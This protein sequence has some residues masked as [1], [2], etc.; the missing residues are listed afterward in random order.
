MK[1][2]EMAAAL[3]AT[4]DKRQAVDQ[5][6]SDRPRTVHPSAIIGRD[7]RIGRNVDIGP[8]AV[9]GDG[10]EIG[11]DCRLS[12]HAVIGPQ[13]VIGER[14][15]VDSFAVVGGEPQDLTYDP[16]TRSGVRVGNAVTIR[17]GVTIHRSTQNDVFTEIS[18]NCYLMANS[19]V[20][21]DCRLGERV[22][23]SNNVMLAGH[24]TVEARAIIGG[25]AGVHQHVRIGEGA[26]VGGNASIS[27]DVPPFTIAAE[28]NRLFGLNRIGL[29]RSGMSRA[30]IRDLERCYTI[31]FRQAGDIRGKA[32][33]ALV[34]ASPE[35]T[36]VGLRFLAFF[37][38]GRRGF[39]FPRRRM[40]RPAD[41]D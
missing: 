15:L 27:S 14:T 10:S 39:S 8:F 25:G 6:R 17:E 2:T 35:R 26:M 11:D 7:V 40:H 12:T 37:N 41:G 19:H 32:A 16:A 28:R 4:A 33:S 13:T 18:D 22:V 29:R 34:V 9:I 1:P 21:H 36:A 38:A 30:E 5:P 24:V 3:Y 23:L 31:V 20:A